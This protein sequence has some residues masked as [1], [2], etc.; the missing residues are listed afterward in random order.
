MSLWIVFMLQDMVLVFI[1]KPTVLV[2]QQDTNKLI[3]SC[4]FS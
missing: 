1:R 3:F 2:S 4:I